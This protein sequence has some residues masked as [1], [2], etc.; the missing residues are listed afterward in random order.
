M[1]V[2]QKYAL[3]RANDV[4]VISCLDETTMMFAKSIRAAK[5]NASVFICNFPKTASYNETK[6]QNEKKTYRLIDVNAKILEPDLFSSDANIR[7]I[8]MNPSEEKN[9]SDALRLIEQFRGKKYAE[10]YTFCASVESECILD[11]IDKGQTTVS[12]VRPIKVRRV[13]TIRNQVYEYLFN[14]SLFESVSIEYDEKIISVLI[15]GMGRFG[16]EI[17]KAVL[18]CGQMDNY[19]LRVNVIDKD[20]DIESEFYRQCPGIRQRGF[21][22]RN[23]EDYYEISFHGGVEVH[24]EK[25]LDVL[26]GIPNATWAFVNLG[27]ESE[28][29]ETAIRLR[30]VYSGIQIDEGKEPN[31]SIDKIQMPRIV[32]AVQNVQKAILLRNNALVN[33]KNQHYQI[34]ALGSDAELFSYDN[35]FAS[36]MEHLALT[37]HLQWGDAESFEKFEYYRRSSMAS[38]I[39]KKYRDALMNDADLKAALE[40]KRW[41]AYMRSTEGYSFGIVRDDLARRHPLLVRYDNLS[42]VEKAKDEKLNNYSF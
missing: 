24:S 14:N 9:L 30:S 35:L 41:N 5:P 16:A 18:W 21:L 15:V 22:P 13:N 7:F 2:F 33:F 26:H 27:T 31:H 32:V 40:H 1:N 17:L 39:H 28:N 11:T 25:F 20:P 4:Y 12:G 38:A 42:S 6:T 23:G 3:S 10:I 37:A 8:L 19:V 34:D 29:I 36:K